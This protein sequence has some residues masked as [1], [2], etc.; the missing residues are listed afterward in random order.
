MGAAAGG[1]PGFTP[2]SRKQAQARD[3]R[4]KRKIT[5]ATANKPA[6]M[7]PHRAKTECVVCIST[8]IATKSN[9]NVEETHTKGWDH[10][11]GMRTE[12]ASSVSSSSSDDSV[13]PRSECVSS[14]AVGAIAAADMA[15]V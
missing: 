6:I 12:S 1:T 9:T 15:M 5:H 10:Q 7:N 4:T 14:T 2:S 13:G 8:S 3:Q 11:L